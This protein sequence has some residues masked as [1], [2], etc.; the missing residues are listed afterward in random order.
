MTR[1]ASAAAGTAGFFASVGFPGWLAYPVIAAEVLGGLLL[2]LGVFPRWVAAVLTLEL[3]GAVTV[4][5]GN[6][7]QFTAPNGGWEYPFFLATASL[8]LAMLGDGAYALRPSRR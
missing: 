4:H 2:I 5:L 7:W 1:R 8:A 3:L 6:G